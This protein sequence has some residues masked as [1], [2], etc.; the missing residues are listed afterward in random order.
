MNNPQFKGKIPMTIVL[1][2]LDTKLFIGYI[3][4]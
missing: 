2:M 1:I 4:K 3:L